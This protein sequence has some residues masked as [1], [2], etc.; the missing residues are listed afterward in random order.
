[1]LDQM[2]ARKKN[3]YFIE[4]LFFILSLQKMLN[5]MLPIEKQFSKI[6]F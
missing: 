6:L 1:M 2:F 3:Q 4:I 5:Q